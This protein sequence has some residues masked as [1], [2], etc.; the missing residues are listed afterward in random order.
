[1]K[2]FGFTEVGVELLGGALIAAGYLLQ[3]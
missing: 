1:M 3:L 2:R